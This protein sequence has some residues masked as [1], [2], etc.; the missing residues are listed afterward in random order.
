M[1]EI[2]VKNLNKILIAEERITANPWDTE[3]WNVLLR[4]AQVSCVTFHL[5]L[6]K[7]F[8]VNLLKKVGRFLKN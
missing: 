1:T 7:Q 3:A 2:K 6:M 8:R 5:I 4:D